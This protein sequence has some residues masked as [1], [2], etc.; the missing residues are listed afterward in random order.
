MDELSIVIIHLSL[1][2]CHCC[3]EI[4]CIFH[5]EMMETKTATHCIAYDAQSSI[6][7]TILYFFCEIASEHLIS[8]W[9]VF[10]S[11]KLNYENIQHSQHRNW[12]CQ[13][14]LQMS[15]AQ[16]RYRYQFHLTTSKPMDKGILVLC[17]WKPHSA[18]FNKFIDIFSLCWIPDINSSIKWNLL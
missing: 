17:D 11:I 14:L 10:N 1:A 3:D 8:Y 16:H 13:I 18:A 4:F 5:F 6:N 15:K 9:F 2:I 12:L 7:F